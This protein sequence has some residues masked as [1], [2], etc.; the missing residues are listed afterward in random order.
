MMMVMMVVVMG[1]ECKRKTGGG[2]SVGREKVLWGEEYKRTLH[3]IY[4]GRILFEKVGK[5]ERRF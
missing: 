5:A 1:Y 2:G 3:N 4:E